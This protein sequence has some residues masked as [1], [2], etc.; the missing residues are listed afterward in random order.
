MGKQ[1][2]ESKYYSA[3]EV[4]E[5]LSVSV[6]TLRRLREK[7]G[8]PPWLL[9]GSVVRYRI[10]GFAAWE[11]SSVRGDLGGPTQL[12]LE[13]VKPAKSSLKNNPAYMPLIEFA[14]IM[15]VSG[16]FIHTLIKNKVG[17]KAFVETSGTRTWSYSLRTDVDHFL[18]A[19][20]SKATGT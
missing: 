13:L 9:V 18:E 14:A 19:G 2:T 3:R 1:K 16:P 6:P 15:G 12:K 7:G 8:G 10:E 11:K 5:R 20:E 4:S 17:P